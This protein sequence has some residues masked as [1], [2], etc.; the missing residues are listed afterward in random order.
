MGSCCFPIANRSP[1]QD[2]LVT[3]A[4]AGRSTSAQSQSVFREEFTPEIGRNGSAV[5]GYSSGPDQSFAFS[6][7]KVN[8]S[9]NAVGPS[10][11]GTLRKQHSLNKG[12]TVMKRSSKRSLRGAASVKGM[13][14]I[15]DEEFNNVFRVPIP[16]NANPT[17]VLANRFQGKMSSSS[18]S[19]IVSNTSEAWRK[20]LK[21][22][23]TFFR[24]VQLS[25]E[26]RSKGFMRTSN[27]INSVSAPTVLRAEGGLEDALATLR[28]YNKHAL[29]ES[30]KAREIE[31]DVITQ[32]N[33]LRNDLTQKIKE[34]KSLAGDFRN[35]VDREKDITRRQVDMF[36]EAITMADKN[37][38]AATGKNDPFIMRLAVERQVAKQI[39]EENYLHRVDDP[40]A[41]RVQSANENAGL[42]ESRELGSRTR[43]DCGGRDTKGL[44]C[45]CYHS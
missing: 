24:E 13:A 17:E 22:L 36:R 45:L 11:V 32:L 31:E 38:I 18:R 39:E 21:D 14:G 37:P 6:N 15:P 3:P 34:I 25:Y 35:N 23:I 8:N 16:T 33:G 9:V 1:L 28:G 29:A 26:A 20:L 7:T 4:D 2:H 12:T 10:K 42:S 40:V 19:C 27:I 30:N 44:Q 5:A 43:V 41:H